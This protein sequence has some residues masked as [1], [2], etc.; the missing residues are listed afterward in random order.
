MANL[1]SLHPTQLLSAL[2]EG[3]RLVAEHVGALEQIASRQEG[4]A[5]ARAVEVLRV[6]SDEEAGKF[7]ILLDVARAVET[8][9][10]L[11]ADQLRKAGNHIAK[12]IYQRAV[13]IRP[14][15]FAEL[16]RFAKGLRAS[17]YLDGPNDVDWIFRNEIEAER[18]E[19]LYVDY[20]ATDDGDSWYS[21]SRYDDLGP[22]YPSGAVELVLAMTRAGFCSAEVLT[23]IVDVWHEFR[24]EPETHWRDCRELNQATLER[25]PVDIVDPELSDEDVSR[26]L[27][28]WTFP[29]YD[30]DLRK[31]DVKLEDLRERQRNW[32]PDGWGR[33]DYY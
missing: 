27:N 24:P 26:I 5:A 10:A 4:P 13:D 14:A 7:L 18:E 1:A 2:A 32:S 29:M 30:V 23:T 28:T 22:D 16:L 20:V 15:D 21:P 6:V 17:H 33:G 31:I 8:E 25:I 19:K 11:K 12:G 9:P 3:L